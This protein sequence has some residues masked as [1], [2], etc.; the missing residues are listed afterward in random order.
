MCVHDGDA[1]SWV[2]EMLEYRFCFVYVC[3]ARDGLLSLGHSRQ[4]LYHWVTSPGQ[5]YYVIEQ[6]LYV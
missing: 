4:A 1:H 5:E 3:G 6:N 2:A